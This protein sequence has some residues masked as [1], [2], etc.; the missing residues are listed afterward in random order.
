LRALLRLALRR[1]WGAAGAHFFEDEDFRELEAAAG[2]F[3][4]VV[5]WK[6]FDPFFAHLS[7]INVPRFGAEVI[8]WELSAVFGLAALA[9]LVAAAVVVFAA[10]ALLITALLFGLAA[11][12][13]RFAALLFLLAALLGGGL[14]FSARGALVR[15]L[16]TGGGVGLGRGSCGVACG[17]RRRGFLG[18]RSL[19]QFLSDF[20]GNVPAVF[21]C[22]IHRVCFRQVGFS[23]R[24]GARPIAA[25][26]WLIFW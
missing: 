6:E 24:V 1:R 13:F 23:S 12:I 11:L 9:F 17:G 18:H 7:E 4:G 14:R 25:R 16:G 5:V 10:E 20:G 3:A 19:G 22:G 8:D 2:E 26:A 21:G 15:R